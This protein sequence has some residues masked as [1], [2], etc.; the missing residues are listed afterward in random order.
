ML[1]QIKFIGM[2]LATV[3]AIAIMVSGTIAVFAFLSGNGF[4]IFCYSMQHPALVIV[5]VIGAL[6]CT[7]IYV[8][9][10]KP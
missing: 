6:V 5:S 4:S 1:K 3:I 2:F 8:E 10:H 9:M 7:G